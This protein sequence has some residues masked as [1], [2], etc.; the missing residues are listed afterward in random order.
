[1]SL[2]EGMDALRRFGR[3]A[4]KK[5]KNLV[6]EVKKAAG[7]PAGGPV[8]E[9]NP[10]YYLIVAEQGAMVRS[11]VELD[12]PEIGGLR[13]G[14][15]VTVVEIVGRRGRISDPLD[16]WISL[17][18]NQGEKILK[19]TFP[20]DNKKQIQAMERRFERL[21]QA[22]Q[23]NSTQREISDINPEFAHNKSL[24]LSPTSPSV[25]LPRLAPPQ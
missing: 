2:E 4:M 11:G 6:T 12:S 8:S 19:Q 21:K 24:P 25:P 22:Q 1:M 17:E 3:F 16:G 7:L 13:K 15:V 9:S 14:E 10:R 23:Q 18:T 20:P 5:T